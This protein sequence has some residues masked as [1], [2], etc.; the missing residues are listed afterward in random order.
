[1]GALRYKNRKAQAL[2]NCLA[3]Q[4]KPHYVE[5]EMDSVLEIDP[6]TGKRAMGGI[7]KVSN[8]HCSEG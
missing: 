2:Y 1:M 4:E 3:I 6:E 8:R 7:V 5:F